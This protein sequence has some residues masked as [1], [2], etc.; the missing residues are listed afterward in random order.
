MIPSMSGEGGI[1]LLPNVTMVF[2]CVDGGKPFVSRHRREAREVHNLLV[3]VL[4]SVLQQVR[5]WNDGASMHFRASAL[6]INDG[7]VS[8]FGLGSYRCG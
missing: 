4:R 8:V 3:S 5:Q 2:C 6:K 7:Q 1:T